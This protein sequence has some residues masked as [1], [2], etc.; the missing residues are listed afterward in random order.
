MTARNAR[1][2][3]VLRAIVIGAVAG[4]AYPIIDVALACRMPQSEACVWGKAYF[5]LSLGIS[6]VVIGGV[7]AAIAYILKR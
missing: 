5:P 3:R 6:M 4:A 2:K 1:T 7:V